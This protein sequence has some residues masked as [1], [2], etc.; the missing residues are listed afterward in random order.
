MEQII[1]T[2][3]VLAHL[4]KKFLVLYGNRI[5]ITMLRNLAFVTY[6][7]PDEYNQYPHTLFL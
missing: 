5:V 4:G 6:S 2:K 7:E 1:L 3:A